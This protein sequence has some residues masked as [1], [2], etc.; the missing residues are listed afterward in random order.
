MKTIKQRF[1]T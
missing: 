1:D